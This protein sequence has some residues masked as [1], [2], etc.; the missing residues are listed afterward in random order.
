MSDLFAK[1]R[2]DGGYFGVYRAAGDK[3]VVRPILDSLPGP[4]MESGGRR[5]IMWGI[6]SYL[7][8]T[9]NERIK[10]AAEAS[11]ARYSTCTPMG[12]RLLT[13][14]TTRHEAL[15]QR[16]AEYCGKQASVL[17]NYG[18]LGVMGTI[19]AL[20]GPKDVV[21]IDKLSH[22]SMI[23]GTIL[24]M[25]GRRF[26]PFRHNDM[27]SLEQQLRAERERG[28]GGILIVIEG[29]YG[30][31]GDLANLPDIA[32]LARRYEA[33]IFIDDAHG[34]GV[35][36]AGG[37]G[38]AEHFGVQDE[39]DLYF[40]TFAKAFAAIG[41]VTAGDPEVIEYIRFNARTNV[42]A[43]ALPMVYVDVLD[44]TLDEILAHPEYRARMWHNA[45]AL[46]RGLVELGYS[47]GDTQSP[48]TPVYIPSGPETGRAIMVMLREEYG[49]FLSGV[50]YPVVP[51]GINLFRMIPTALHTDQDVADT[52]AAFA[53]IRDRLKLD[54]ASLNNLS[55]A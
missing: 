1:C 17:F 21:I 44:A 24:A 52:L 3:Y 7:G 16:L 51:R 27:E 47:I 50:T 31:R 5:V 33:R 40:G 53:E 32:A 26:R 45:H 4:H 46:Q 29:V 55:L 10:A 42:F 54:L 13:G 20:I 48:V 35:M 30:M 22:A 23:D 12:S 38:T 25:A 28:A 41:G 14:N 15:E 36:G 8:L 43:K 11:V 6:N 39:I 2:G 49:V 37:R 18:Y 34:F 9:G 19:S